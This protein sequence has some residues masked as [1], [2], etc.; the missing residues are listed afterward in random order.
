MMDDDADDAAFKAE[1][2]A[3]MARGDPEELV[4]VVI[5]LAFAAE[6]QGWAED[7]C[8][9]LAVHADA[10]VR[11]N[12]VIGFVHLAQRFEEIDEERVRP[13]I[14]AALG[15]DKQYVREQAE[16]ALLELRESYGW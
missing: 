3:A 14:E 11:G 12:A 16:A 4:G 13:A 10:T 2:E 15:D 1:I 6:D 8:L 9:R 7:C 5:D